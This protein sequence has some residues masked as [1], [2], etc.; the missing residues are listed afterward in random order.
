MV[1]QLYH[2]SNPYRVERLF[3]IIS[4]HIVSYAFTVHVII[5]KFTQGDIFSPV[6]LK[7]FSCLLR[8]GGK[9]FLLVGKSPKLKRNC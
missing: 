6:Q 7:D 3:Y 1:F 5:E 8:N 9:I 4:Y 2:D